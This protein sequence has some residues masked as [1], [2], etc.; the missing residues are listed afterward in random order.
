MFVHHSCRLLCNWTSWQP[1]SDYWIAATFV[2]GTVCAKQNFWKSFILKRFSV[3]HM[4]SS[5]SHCQFSMSIGCNC[6]STT[7]KLTFWTRT[8]KQPLLAWSKQL[9]EEKLTMKRLWMDNIKFFKKKSYF[10]L[11]MWLSI[12]LRWRSHHSHR[13]FASNADKFVE[14]NLNNFLLFT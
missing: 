12:C 11:T 8:N 3:S 14:T 9:L 2:Q 10:S 4:S 1:T 13:T 5:T 6:C 7:W